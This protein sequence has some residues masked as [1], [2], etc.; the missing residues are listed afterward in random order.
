MI[1]LFK[2]PVYESKLSLDLEKI[3]SKC[4][5]VQKKEKGR[6]ASTRGGW[7]SQ[8]IE[9]NISDKSFLQLYAQIL[10]HMD[11]YINLIGAKG[12]VEID[13]LWININKPGTNNISHIHTNSFISGTVYIQTNEETGNIYFENPNPVGYDWKQKYFN[14]PDSHMDCN[15]TWDFVPENNAIYLFPSWAKHGVNTNMS[16]MNRVSISFNG[17]LKEV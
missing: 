5:E 1:N 8:F 11:T 6:Q 4:Y 12:N 17:R 16:N 9:P 13:V 3:K 15:D 10:S 14:E 7:Q 2:T